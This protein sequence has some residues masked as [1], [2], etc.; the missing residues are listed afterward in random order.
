M[1]DLFFDARPPAPG[2]SHMVG[3]PLTQFFVEF[4]T[5]PANRFRMQARDLREQFQSAMSETLGL[6]ACHPPAL[7]LI[8]AAQQQIELPMIV[9]IRMVTRPTGRTSTLVNRQFRCHHSASFLGVTGSLLQT[10]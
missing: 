4:V 5:A 10:V 2:E 6:A 7:L 9:S 8:Q 3:R 1:S